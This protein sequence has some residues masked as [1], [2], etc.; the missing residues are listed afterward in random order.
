MNKRALDIKKDLTEYL[1][2]H[3]KEEKIDLLVVDQLATYIHIFFELQEEVMQGGAVQVY[4]SGASA[5][6]GN[7]TSMNKAMDYIEKLSYKVGIYEII[8][9]KL[10]SYGK[11]TDGV[12]KRTK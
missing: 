5:P 6:S 3:S 2:R 4:E 10:M 9:S 7:F 12:K 11:I 1:K 8:K